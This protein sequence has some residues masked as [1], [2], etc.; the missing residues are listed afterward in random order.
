MTHAKERVSY[1]LA[2]A[3]GEDEEEEDSVMEEEVE[4]NGW[5]AGD[6]DEA[7]D[8]PEFGS[9]VFCSLNC[10]TFSKQAAYQSSQ[11]P[12]RLQNEIRMFCLR[13]Q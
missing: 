5:D 12:Q 11:R 13:W 2:F 4:V 10:G 9:H 1:W 6:E 7:D 8:K 3:L